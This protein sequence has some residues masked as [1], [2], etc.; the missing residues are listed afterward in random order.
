MA[1]NDIP[2]SR[3][4]HSDNIREIQSYLRKIGY[5]GTDGN[6]IKP[7]GIY[8]QHTRDAV[9]SYQRDYGL[10]QTGEVD[11]NT[12]RSIHNTYTDTMNY[13]YN[14]EGI[15]AFPSLDTILDIDDKGTAVVILQAM[16]NTIAGEF[17]NIIPITLTGIYDEKTAEAVSE[18]Q[19]IA[20]IMPNG[21]T[22]LRTWNTITQLFNHI[23]EES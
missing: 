13:I 18:L 15:F 4:V 8:G 2:V 20:G 19:Y 14:Q 7:D 5:G 16:I 10:P 22:N 6:P 11:H 17:I 21:Q 12:W 23:A 3:D 1:E 9:L